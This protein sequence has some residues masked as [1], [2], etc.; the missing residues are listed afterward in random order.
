MTFSFHTGRTTLCN[1]IQTS[2]LVSSNLGLAGR[3]FPHELYRIK[4]SF[5][6]MGSCVITTN[7]GTWYEWWCTCVIW[8]DCYHNCYFSIAIFAAPSL[9]FYHAMLCFFP[10]QALVNEM[11]PII[12]NPEVIEVRV[13]HIA[14]RSLYSIPCDL[15][16]AQVSQ[17][18]YGF[19][20][21]R[22][23]NGTGWIAIYKPVDA[24]RTAV[25]IINDDIIPRELSF[26]FK[27]VP[28]SPCTTTCAVRDIY[29]RTDLGTYDGSF[30]V[31]GVPMH[32][33]VFVMISTPSRQNVWQVVV[34]WHFFPRCV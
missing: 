3:H 17:S 20:G 25:L 23:A 28:G 30:L 21:S 14:W 15:L 34:N 9:L 18:Y 31:N 10:E 19:S 33:S 6:R 7:S 22:F 12:A 5:L 16:L 11:W 8:R 29:S 32:D 26:S 24:L 27:D 2:S 13:A 4:V 1:E